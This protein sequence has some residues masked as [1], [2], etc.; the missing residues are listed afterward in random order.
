M[1]KIKYFLTLLA[2]CCCVF[3]FIGCEEE[4]FSSPEKNYTQTRAANRY[5]IDN[6]DFVY[7]SNYRS[8]SIRFVAK[9]DIE[10][11][12]VKSVMKDSTG[13]LLDSQVIT[14]GDV[15]EGQQYIVTSTLPDNTITN[16]KVIKSCEF[17]VYS[18]TVSYST[19]PGLYL[20]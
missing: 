17:S 20:N 15:I 11:L 19:A 18:G 2:I 3:C 16:G 1:K 9:N 6:V 12:V 14:V 4:I 10:D 5:D 13:F 8:V 7:S